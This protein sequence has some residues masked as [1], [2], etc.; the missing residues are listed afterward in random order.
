MAHARMSEAMMFQSNFVPAESRVLEN[1]PSGVGK[2]EFA[3]SH[4]VGKGWSE[5]VGLGR[6][7]QV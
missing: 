1:L 7:G 4:M 2:M 6:H 3:K 5:G